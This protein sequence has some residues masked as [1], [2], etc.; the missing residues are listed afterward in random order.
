MY[1]IRSYYVSS[2]IRLVDKKALRFI[3]EFADIYRYVLDANDKTL[4]EAEK[5]LAFVKSYI[6]LQQLRYGKNL[7]IEP[8]YLQCGKDIYVVPLSVQILVENAIKHRNN[9]V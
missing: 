3:E 9:F 8:E 5:E 2:L 4:V 7:V 1:A 6:F